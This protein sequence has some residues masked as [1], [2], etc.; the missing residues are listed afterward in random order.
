VRISV[1][2]ND[3]GL[4]PDAIRARVF[5]DG[6]LISDCFTADEEKGEAHCYARDASGKMIIDGDSI[7]E[8]VRRGKVR[9]EIAP[10][11]LAP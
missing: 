10:L 9:I 6:A 8:E 7:R 11:G 1:R 5:L 4:R 2:A 3:P